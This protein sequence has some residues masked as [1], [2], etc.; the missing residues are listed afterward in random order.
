MDQD[1]DDVDPDCA[2]DGALDLADVAGLRLDGEVPDA[3]I[4]TALA[5]AG[6][7]DGDGSSDLIVGAGNY[8]AGGTTAT[9]GV[10]VVQGTLE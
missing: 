9:G 2:W 6:D 7:L 5:D 1:C 4:A 10:W 3:Y 8:D